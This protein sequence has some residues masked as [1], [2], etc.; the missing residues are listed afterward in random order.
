MK[1]SM[2]GVERGKATIIGHQQR[3]YHVGC[4]ARIQNFLIQREILG[5]L[6]P[7]SGI[8][9]VFCTYDSGRSV[10]NGLCGARSWEDS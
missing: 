7:R 4:V 6:N 8:S 3:P 2:A 5:G 1:A 10:E 9:F